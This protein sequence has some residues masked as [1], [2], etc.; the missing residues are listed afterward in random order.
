MSGIEYIVGDET[1]GVDFDKSIELAAS[2]D[3][4]EQAKVSNKKIIGNDHLWEF[5]LNEGIRAFYKVCDNER[6]LLVGIRKHPPQ[7]GKAYQRLY[8]KNPDYCEETTKI[9]K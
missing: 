8:R 2:P 5:Y 9:S 1:F 7:S 3:K 6:M 4:I